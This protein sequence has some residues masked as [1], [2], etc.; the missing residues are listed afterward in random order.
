MELPLEHLRVIDLSSGPVGGMASMILSDF[1]ADV[2]KVERPGGD[3]FRE[4][5]NSPMWLRGKR[6]IELDLKREIERERLYRLVE[7]SDVVLTAFRAHSAVDL[8]CD[9]DVLAG[10]NPGIV[11]CQISGFGP[12]GP[13]VGY[14]GYEAVVAAK[15]GRMQSFSGM[16]NRPGPIYSTVPASTLE[17]LGNSLRGEYS[18]ATSLMFERIRLRLE[19]ISCRLLYGNIWID[20]VLKRP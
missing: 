20:W 14:P 2:I 11:Y 7:T 10:R 1:G 4:L 13:Y 8:G 3:P 15:A 6:S 19:I 9:Y 16:I 5:P 12:Y 17:I 18:I